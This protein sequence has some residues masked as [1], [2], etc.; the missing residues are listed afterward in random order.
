M[1]VPLVWRPLSEG[2]EFSLHTDWVGASR[3][4][5]LVVTSDIFADD[6]SFIINTNVRR[7]T[8]TRISEK[9]PK[10]LNCPRPLRGM[11]HDQSD[12]TTSPGGVVRTGYR[13]ARQRHRASPSAP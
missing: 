13:F 1:L 8:T 9:R 4:P 12:S 2:T 10:F 11:Q 5:C 3:C 7:N 6:P